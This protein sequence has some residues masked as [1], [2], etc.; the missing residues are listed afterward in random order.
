MIKKIITLIFVAGILSA[1]PG[2]AWFEHISNETGLPDNRVTSILQ[3]REGF[4]WFGTLAGVVRYDGYG[5]DKYDKDPENPN[6]LS[7][8]TVWDMCQDHAGNIWIGTF[9]GLNRLDPVTGKIQI[10]L[11][12]PN[13][14]QSIS[15]NI[16]ICMLEDMD[17][18]LWIGTANGLN[19]YNLVTN[20]F[21]PLPDFGDYNK[22]FHK[23]RIEAI[24]S[25]SRH[26]IWISTTEENGQFAGIF[27]YD[28]VQKIIKKIYLDV[29]SPELA[30]KN[31]VLVIH[32]D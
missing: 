7:Q 21:E 23:L 8:N 5:F 25:D 15:S 26:N 4:L 28:P 31:P 17:H 29:L 22:L 20:T 1:R 3:D 19:L 10:Y 32:E 14:S 12:D 9:K 6:S 18:Y 30:A 24:Y 11:H 13:D 16:V 27:C 2:D